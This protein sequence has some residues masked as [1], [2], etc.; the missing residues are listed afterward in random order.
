MQVKFEFPNPVDPRGLEQKPLNR[1]P[2]V[3]VKGAS[4]GGEGARWVQVK[5]K[6]E[7]RS[8][9]AIGCWEIHGRFL[10]R[11]A[12][13]LPC[14]S[15]WLSP[16]CTEVWSCPFHGSSRLFPFGKHPARWRT[17]LSLLSTLAAVS[18]ECD[19]SCNTRAIWSSKTLSPLLRVKMPVNTG[20]G[21]KV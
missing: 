14:P 5:A 3:R 18:W 17:H 7:H 6:E 1:A 12:P 19:G 16:L 10:R 21:I 13:L 9:S 15:P 2:W 4:V 20:D 11:R 8:S